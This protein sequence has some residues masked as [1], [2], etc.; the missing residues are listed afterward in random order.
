MPLSFKERQKF[1]KNV[2]TLDLTPFRLHSEEVEK[3]GLV[4]VIMPKFKNR[5][6][7]KYIDPLIKSTDFRIKLDKFGSAVWMKMD[8][9]LKVGNIIDEVSIAFGSEIQQANERVTKFIFQLYEQRLISFN[10]LN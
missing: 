6:A 5:L 10:E 1:L 8:G 3:D 7:K 9:N 4:T 2:N